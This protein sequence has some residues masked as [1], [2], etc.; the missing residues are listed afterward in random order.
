MKKLLILLTL[1]LFLTGCTFKKVENV[2]IESIISKILYKEN[3]LYNVVL[4]GYKYYL[5]LGTTITNKTDYNVTIKD[6]YNKYYLYI[7]TIAYY[8]KTTRDFEESSKAFY[9]KELV[10][11]NKKGYIEINEINNKYF[12]EVMYNYAKIEAYINKSDLQKSL[13]NISYILSSVKYN[14]KLIQVMLENDT[15]EYDAESLDI[16]KPKRESGNFLDYIKTYENKNNN[17][18]KKDEDNITT[19]ESI[20]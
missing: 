11:D 9:S 5:P 18:N 15:L 19:E 20:E 16:F 3:K 4:E 14:D 1:V 13:V 8:H 10:N 6:K 12:V 7:D 17:D 2:S